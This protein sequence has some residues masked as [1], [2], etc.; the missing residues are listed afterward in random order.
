MSQASDMFG[1][2]G[3]AGVGFE[4]ALEGEGLGARFEGDRGLDFPGGKVSGVGTSARVVS[5]QTEE[6]VQ[7]EHTTKGSR[8]S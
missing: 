3:A 6:E 1:G 2:K 4:V 5:S 8:A 7:F